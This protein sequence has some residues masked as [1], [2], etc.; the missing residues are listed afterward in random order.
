MG[1]MKPAWYYARQAEEAEA[2]EAYFRTRPAPTPPATVSQRATAIAYYRTLNIK[3]GNDSVIFPVQVDV[4]ARTLIAAAPAA[5]YTA[6]G[7]LAAE[8]TTGTEIV[9]DRPRGFFPSKASWY[10]G[11]AAPIRDATPYNTRWTKYYATTGTGAD[12]RSHYSMPISVAAGEVTPT[13]VQAAFNAIFKN[14]D[15]TPKTAVLGTKNGRA[16]LQLERNK[17]LSVLT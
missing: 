8:P 14:A 1:K 7:L 6:A 5:A 13:G 3:R 12:A 9:L 2:R 10:A 15:G 17:G 16:S 4:A 11:L